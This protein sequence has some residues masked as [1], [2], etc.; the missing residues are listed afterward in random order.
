MAHRTVLRLACLVTLLAV[1]SS[2]KK[3][4]SRWSR[5]ISTYTSDISDW[6]PLSGPVEREPEPL[7]PIKRQAV[8]EPRILTEPFPGLTRP[9]GFGQDAFTSRNYY[10]SP[11]NRHLFLQSVPSAPQNYL[12]DQ[13][14]GQGIRFGLA[15]PNFP[16]SQ[17]FVAPPLGFDNIQPQK[18]RLPGILNPVSFTQGLPGAAQ[19]KP[20]LSQSQKFKSEPKL[21]DGYRAENVSGDFGFNVMKKPQS[22]QKIK[23]DTIDKPVRPETLSPNS[24]HEREEVQL[25]YVP[26]E[27]LNRGQFNY[28]SPM[29]TSQLVNSELY[30]QA[31]SRPNPLKQTFINDYQ[32]PAAKPLEPVSGQNYFSE[33]N[34]QLKDVDQV[35]KYSTIQTPFPTQPPTT[36]KPKKLK[37]HQPPLAIFMT[38]EVSKNSQVK[39]GDVLSSLKNAD[40]IAVLDSV[41][42][43]NAPKVFIGPSTL[44]PPEN[45]VKFELPYLSNI[46]NSDKK[47]KQLPFFVAP[48]SYNTPNGF[49]KIPFPSPHV[50]SVVINSQI[51]DSQ[52][53]AP[54]PG[55]N[56]NHYA[57]PTYKPEKPVTQ[58]PTFSYYSTA[59]PKPNP[60]PNYQSNYYSFEPQTVSSIR[61][62]KQPETVT[63][64]PKTGSYFI[65]NMS[66]QY[67][68]QDYKLQEYYQQQ[69]NFKSSEVN[70]EYNFQRKPDHTTTLRTTTT[71]TTTTKP[72]STYPSQLLETHNPYSINQAF[73]FSTPLDY[74]NYFDDVKQPYATPGAEGHS[75]PAPSPS[76]TPLPPLPPPASP[77][78]TEQQPEQIITQK[79]KYHQ[80]STPTYLQNYTPEI[81]Y[82][83]DPN[84][85]YPVF[86]PTDYFA[87]TELTSHQTQPSNPV[88]T[89]KKS[90]VNNY[91]QEVATPVRNNYNQDVPV[92]NNY[93][94]EIP[95]RNNYNQDVP[96]RNNYNQDVP[97]RNNYN[98]DVTA[99]ERNNYNTEVNTLINNNYNT[100]TVSNN[101][102]TDI[103]SQV[104]T[105]KT[106][107]NQNVESQTTVGQDVPSDHPTDVNNV[108]T[109]SDID[110][111]PKYNSDEYNAYQTNVEA[112]EVSPTSS[113]TTTTTTTRRTPQR[114]RGRPRYTTT[115]RSESYESTSKVVVSRRP[116]RERRPLPSRPRYEP[117]KITTE[118]SSK[119]PIDSSESTTKPTRQRIR[120]RIQYKP[121]EN[122]DIYDR[123]VKTH[124]TKEEDLAYQRDVLHQNYPVTLMER[125]STVDIEAMTEPTPKENS[126]R[127]E[128]P[129]TENDTANAYT[130][131]K[132]SIT[133]HFSN[134]ES[135]EESALPTFTARSTL[136]AETSYVPN[137]PSTRQEF[138]YQ[139][140]SS[141][142]PVESSAYDETS[143]E[144]EEDIY[145]KQTTPV[146]NQ[147]YAEI[148][149]YGTHTPETTP[150]SPATE[151]SISYSV[152]NEFATVKQDEEPATAPESDDIKTETQ[153]QTETE[154]EEENVVQ[155]T[156][157]YNRVRVRPGVIRQYHQASTE[158]SRNK[159]R[160]RPAQP[161]TYRPAYDR[162]RTTMRID[163]IEA[164]LKTKQ[165]HARPEVQEIK[166][167]VYR[168][169]P[170]TESSVT[171]STTTESATKRGHFRRRRPSYSYTTTSTESS[172]T[173]RIYEVK[174]RFR[175]RRPTEKP[176]DKPDVQTEA[177]SSTTRSQLHTRYS[178]RPRLSERYNKKPES[179]ETQEDQDSNFSIN[180][181]KYV[182]PETDQWSPKISSDTFK[183][184]N[185]NDIVDEQKIATTERRSDK[186]GELDIITARN[187]YEDI[188]LTV[189]P[190]SNNRANKKIPEIPP[191]LEALVEQSKVTRSDSTDAMS[192]FE[193]MLEEVMKSLEEQDQDEYTKNVMKHKGG[194]IGEIPPERIISSGDTY[195]QKSTTPTEEITTEQTTAEDSSLTAEDDQDRSSR[196]R[197][198]WKKVKVRPATTESIEFAESQYYTHT[199]NRLG[200]PVKLSKNVHDK[201]EK[202][203][204]PKV[205]TYKPSYNFIKDLFSSDDEDNIDV[206]PTVDIHK[207]TSEAPEKDETLI[208]EESKQTTV[209]L[210]HETQTDS[211]ISPGDLDLGTGSPD[212]T[213]DDM[214]VTTPTEPTTTS[215]PA[216]VN[217]PDGG[218]SFMDYLFGTSED[219][220]KQVEDENEGKT[221]EAEIQ[222]TSESPKPKIVTTESAF[223]PD[224]ITAAS[225]SDENTESV[226]AFTDYKKLNST[227]ESQTESPAGITEISVVKV[228]SSSVSS[229]MNP[230]NVVSTSMST[231]VSHETEICFR[232]KC[233]KTSKDIL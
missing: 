86:N 99:P 12:T 142:A 76:P 77:S 153:E 89:D 18:P 70:D 203:E 182:E 191:T 231:E 163:E 166:H 156:P 41:N 53:Q 188:L 17:G 180:R 33:F 38:K 37:P 184:Y 118:K 16:L 23:F 230:A 73:H 57:Q 75:S 135:S 160:R 102:N 176:T 109:V 225:A 186:D 144:K 106:E 116:L 25:L 100:D 127:V 114:I 215:K 178:H 79:P 190:A 219:N 58:K 13:G 140:R 26:L 175:G 78:S 226:T 152:S 52:A 179:E 24:K 48:L 196:R 30:S 223:I 220:N 93:N 3:D 126:E 165:V 183:P 129:I 221:T 187:E 169:E 120:G 119:K 45:F 202:I 207:L 151:Q 185:P 49:A 209:Y 65:N 137:L 172:S 138:F 66:P 34:S 173:K 101:Y 164:D 229:F 21:V 74:H 208:T 213:I 103:D 121:S 145:V 8:A 35:P 212:P 222:V 97:V 91:N 214:Y 81:H 124:N 29:T 113:S 198:F 6:V 199:V 63:S 44:T 105:Y 14:F 111:P 47:L 95:V 194:E 170:T 42:P 161:V 218:F 206:I 148:S 200:Q 149:S 50:G 131:E 210:E 155:T 205:T 201:T 128:E 104:N 147:E 61:P 154:E 139:P 193:S 177:P 159:E 228:E 227:K 92:R 117:N 90:P 132:A 224:E 43:L 85:K 150:A 22:L 10:N 82:D 51:R 216:A 232:G 192:T 4:Q 158:S 1:T 94:Q 96:V 171:S 80:Q 115:P 143:P 141:V 174:N 72:P 197:G 55:F 98:S 189:T 211:A 7:P 27:S 36:P 69:N 19:A 108:P 71:T 83:S 11:A 87:K 67:N 146:S 125:M 2:A 112:A 167:P 181:P 32:R 168:P 64:P 28:K 123:R 130:N 59:A 40:T 88:D 54:Q 195:V 5:Q 136:P 133:Q 204:K 122:E 157:S 217:R 84:L 233:I 39:V 62:P 46:E 68:S 60:V 107:Y 31:N 9:T 110:T 162:R 20:F 15:Q 134:S 56:Q